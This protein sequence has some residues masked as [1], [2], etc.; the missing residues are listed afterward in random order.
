[1][2]EKMTANVIA[3]SPLNYR[4]LEMCKRKKNYNVERKEAERKSKSKAL[5]AACV[6]LLLD[7]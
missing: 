5:S 3:L 6:R 2:W 7:Q 1:M 4:P